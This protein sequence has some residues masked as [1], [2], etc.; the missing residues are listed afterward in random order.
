MSNSTT[1]R[2]EGKAHEIKGAVKE[3]IGHLTGNTHLEA[4]GQVEKLDGKIQKKVGEIKK[5]IEK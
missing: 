4:E 1:D 5:V 3:T 2:V